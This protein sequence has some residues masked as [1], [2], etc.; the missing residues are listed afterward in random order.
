[1][2]VGVGTIFRVAIEGIKIRKRSFEP[3]ER[4]ARLLRP[5]RLGPSYRSCPAGRIWG[6]A[7]IHNV[8]LLLRQ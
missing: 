4:L 3:S 7:A 2:G 5:S 8:V 1:M 6:V